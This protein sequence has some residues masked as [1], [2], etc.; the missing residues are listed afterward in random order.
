MVLLSG[1]LLAIMTYQLDYVAQRIGHKSRTVHQL[2]TVQRVFGRIGG[3][4]YLI[5]MAP[6]NALIY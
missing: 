4:L 1:V 3:M 6:A 5:Y 2:Q